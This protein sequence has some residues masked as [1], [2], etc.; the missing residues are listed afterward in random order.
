MQSYFLSHVTIILVRKTYDE[1]QVISPY[2][3]TYPLDILGG[4]ILLSVMILNP[5]ASFWL[6]TLQ[7]VFSCCIPTCFAGPDHGYTVINIWY[8]VVGNNSPLPLARTVFS[9]LINN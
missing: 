4:Y 5:V 1:I 9:I 2:Y 3:F 6:F 8:R 7:V